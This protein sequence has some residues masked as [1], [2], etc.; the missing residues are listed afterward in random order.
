MT[1]NI[2]TFIKEIKKIKFY[3]AIFCTSYIL[4]KNFLGYS[5]NNTKDVFN[6]YFFSIINL[7]LLLLKNLKKNSYVFFIL[8]IA[9]GQGSFIPIRQPLNQ[10]KKMIKIIILGT[11][12]F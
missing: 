10:A 2:M 6:V 12:R 1:K 7:F 9:S 11:G 5:I 4:G 8:S 3:C